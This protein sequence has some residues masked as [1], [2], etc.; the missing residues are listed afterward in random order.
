MFE[1]QGCKMWI[2]NDW[3]ILNSCSFTVKENLV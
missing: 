1:K 3:F 2:S